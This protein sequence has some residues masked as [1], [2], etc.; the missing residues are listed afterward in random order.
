MKG[1]W[2]G[3]LRTASVVCGILYQYK[4]SNHRQPMV[5]GLHAYRWSSSVICPRLQRLVQ[6]C[7]PSVARDTHVVVNRSGAR[8]TLWGGGPT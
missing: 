3:E 2:F 5:E 6:G 8:A 1:S 4:V 7:G